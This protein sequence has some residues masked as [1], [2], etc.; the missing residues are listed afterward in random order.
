MHHILRSARLALVLILLFGVFV[1]AATPVA[2]L[3]ASGSLRIVPITAYN[4][5]VDSNVESPSTYAPEAATIGAQFCND[6]ATDLTDV[7]AYVGNHATNEPGKYPS[8]THSGLSGTFSLTHEGGSAGLADATRYLAK[9]PAG[10]CATQYWLVSYP[11][12]D[13]AGH[14]VTG[15]IKPDDDLWLQYDLWASANGGA[16]TASMTRTVWMRNEISAAANKIWPNG[17]NKV[18]DQYKQAIADQFGWATFA[19]SGGTTAYP[20]DTVTTQG[21]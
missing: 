3:A 7:F 8:R 9:I 11:R 15:G 12:L 14:T 20:G 16:A 13:A 6:G 5:I 19:P 17:D 18:P 1:P 2:V 21:I 4:F 10:T